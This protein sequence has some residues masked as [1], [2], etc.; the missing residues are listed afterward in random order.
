MA[1]PF[2]PYY[3]WLGIPPAQQPPNH[4]RLLGI[5][6]FEPCLEVIEHAADQRMGYLRTM[7]LGPHSRISQ[8]L[9]GEIAAA[10]SCLLHSGKRAAYDL[11]LRRQLQ[12]AGKS[13]GEENASNS[14]ARYGVLGEYVLLER[15]ADGR[16]GELFRARHRTLGRTVAIK[17]LAKDAQRPQRAERFLRKARLLASLDHPNLVRVYDVGRRDGAWWLAME[18]VDG[19]DLWTMT[20]LRGPLPIHE[21]VEYAIQ[22]AT[23]LGYVH[24]HGVVHRNVKPSNLMVTSGGQVKVIGFGLARP[25]AAPS[26]EADEPCRQLTTSGRVLGTVDYM[27]PEQA[28][29]PRRADA[30]SDIY[31]LG[32]TLCVL[33]TGHSPY[34]G[35]SLLERMIAH[36]ETPIPPLSLHGSVDGLEQAYRKMLAKRPEDRPQSMEAVIE[37]L[38]KIRPNH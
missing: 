3:Q 15:I 13:A 1:V 12:Q 6:L 34:G 35:D 8:R 37:L 29:N 38:R 10:R 11:Q 31:S 33:L 22:A 28:E 36:R 21:A 27:A 30:R 17:V 16:S 5:E 26:V 18:C 23:G 7:Q 24:R 2:D 19:E 14:E 25:G 9:L 20:R 32:C 4:Y